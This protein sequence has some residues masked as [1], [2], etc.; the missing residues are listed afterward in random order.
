MKSAN[1]LIIGQGDIGHQVSNQLAKLGYQVTGMAR[2]DKSH[3]SLDNKVQFWQ[4]DILTVS[5][6]QLQPFTHIAVIVAPNRYS[7]EDYRN[8]YLVIA[9][10]LAKFAEN[11]TNLQRIIFISSTGI[12]GQNKGEWIDE[13]TPPQPPKRAGTQFILQAEQVLQQAFK[14][15]LVIIRPS[16]I[17]GKQRLLRINQATQK[18]KMPM[19]P[20]AWTNRIFDSDLVQIICQVLQLDK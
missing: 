14:Q 11:L 18:N 17:Y 19:S 1:Y 20:C 4:A 2:A 6:E 13:N 3:Y 7:A 12:Y 16:G 15:K 5:E 10:H 9:E 8:C